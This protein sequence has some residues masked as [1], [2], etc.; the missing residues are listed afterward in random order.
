[1][2]KN[3]IQEKKPNFFSSSI[4]CGMQ[5]SAFDNCKMY[6][7]DDVSGNCSVYTGIDVEGAWSDGTWVKLA[8]EI[9]PCESYLYFMAK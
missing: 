7:Y 6:H 8:N 3:Y 1:M 9:T 4:E 2:N 5:C